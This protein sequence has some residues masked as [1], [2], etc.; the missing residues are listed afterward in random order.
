[1]QNVVVFYPQVF[2]A[3][4]PSA[5]PNRQGVAQ[6]AAR[7]L[8]EGSDSEPSQGAGSTSAHLAQR[9]KCHWGLIYS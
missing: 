5:E 6:G 2:A 1:M 4:E 3:L 7:P 9:G 8:A